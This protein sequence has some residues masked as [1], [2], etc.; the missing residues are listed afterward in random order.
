MKD[1]NVLKA[2]TFESTEATCA[3]G[4]R[5]RLGADTVQPRKRS[6]SEGPE[7]VASPG[8]HGACPQQ[9]NGPPEGLELLRGCLK[10]IQAPRDRALL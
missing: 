5:R 6:L 4:R 3:G 7:G 9:A 1:A 8:L 10:A 2:F